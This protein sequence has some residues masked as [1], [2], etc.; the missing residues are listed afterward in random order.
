M[1][2]LGISIGDTALTMTLVK[3]RS[4]S[5][6]CIGYD[7]KSRTLGVEYFN[8]Q[9]YQVTEFPKAEY[10]KLTNADDF[11]HE[12]ARTV[13]AVFELTKVGRVA[14]MIR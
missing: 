10:E 3:V 12:F 6:S 13:L 1:Q 5:L 11:D 14:P 4:K 9:I 7:A 2:K 8:G